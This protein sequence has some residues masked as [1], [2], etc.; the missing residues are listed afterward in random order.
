VLEDLAHARTEL[1][2]ELREHVTSLSD[3]WLE[4]LVLAFAELA[5]NALRHGRLPVRA[6]CVLE[7]PRVLVEVFDSDPS[8]PPFPAIDRDPSFGGMGLC[9]VAGVSADHGWTVQ[10]DVKDVWALL[11]LDPGPAPSA[12]EA[13]DEGRLAGPRESC[14]APVG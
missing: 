7:R 9:M 13:P 3:E 8:R 12:A 2:L 4:N 5:S 10:R 1:R 6:R 14:P 11:V